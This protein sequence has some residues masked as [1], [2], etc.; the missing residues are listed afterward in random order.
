MFSNMQKLKAM[1][2]FYLSE[3]QYNTLENKKGYG[4]TTISFFIYKVGLMNSE[5]YL[6]LD[7]KSRL[8][9]CVIFQKI[10]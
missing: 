6:R 8:P 7:V 10:G 9:D 3:S 4:Q 1:I 2:L 5:T